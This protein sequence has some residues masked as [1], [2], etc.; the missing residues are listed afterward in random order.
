MSLPDPNLQLLT[1]LEALSLK[2][3]QGYSPLVCCVGDE[4]GI[5]KSRKMLRSAEL[6]YWRTYGEVWKPK[7]N[8]FF[9]MSKFKKS[10]FNSEGR[11]FIIEEAEIELGSDDWQSVSNKWFSRIKDTQRIKGNLYI[12]NLPIFMALA[13]KHRRRV[14]WICDVKGRGFANWWKIKKRSAQLLGDEISKAFIGSTILGL[15]DCDAEFDIVDR[16]NK[17]RIEIEQGDLFDKEVEFKKMQK[18][19]K[20][21]KSS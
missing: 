6:I 11:I 12:L 15:P 2:M 7:D 16:L 3:I 14:N 4:T 8:V 13:R 18:E 9:S 5:G 1:P 21:K 20:M 10:L 17:Q 19:A